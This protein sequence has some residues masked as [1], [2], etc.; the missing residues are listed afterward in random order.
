MVAAVLRVNIVKRTAKSDSTFVATTTAGCM[1]CDGTSSWPSSNNLCDATMDARSFVVTLASSDVA[2]KVH[3]PCW[4][5]GETSIVL[6]VHDTQ[7]RSV[8]KPA[9]AQ[10]HEA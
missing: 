7:T 10:L 1:K 6:I 4:W 3:V 9:F 8:R 2:N 5:A